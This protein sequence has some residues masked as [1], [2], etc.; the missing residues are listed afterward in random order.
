M[1]VRRFPSDDLNVDVV[2]AL[3][4]LRQ[5]FTKAE[6]FT[7]AEWKEGD[8]IDFIISI[9]LSVAM[10]SL[11]AVQSSNSLISSALPPGLVAVFVGATSG[12]G[13]T[14]LKHFARHTRKPCAYFIGRSQDAGNRI[15]AE[16]KAINPDGRYIFIKADVSLIRAVDEVCE[17]IKA[18]EKT[19][20]LLFLSA[21][22]PVFD[23][24]GKDVFAHDTSMLRSARAMPMLIHLR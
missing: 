22:M 11:S 4:I 17:Q 14:T 15:M 20:N 2:G 16:C 9:R 23:R 7:T 6:G 18:K 12:I 21:G 24:S 8:F 19:L 10:V 13:E 3:Y 1:H 5:L